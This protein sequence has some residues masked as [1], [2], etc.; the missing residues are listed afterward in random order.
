MKVVVVCE[1]KTEQ[2]LR[3]ALCELIQQQNPLGPRVGV[4]PVAVYGRGA[5]PGIKVIVE[6]QLE[7]PDVSGVILLTDVY[8][9]FRDARE[10]K[11]KL[12]EALGDY[13]RHPKIRIHVAQFEVEAWVIPFWEDICKSLRKRSLKAPPQKP[14]DKP[15][16]I[17]GQK[18]PSRHLKDL[19][20][21]AK[22]RYEKVKDGPKW[23]T[24]R[25][26]GE[27]AKV[28]PELRLFL[29]SLLEFAS[30]ERLP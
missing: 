9:D 3:R 25:N 22:T 19:Y 24:A 13:G 10:A 21:K 4:K 20:R 12:R 28:C 17:N 1:G 15:E 30:A 5:Y 26:L 16:E 14:G 11:D 7:A 27:S 2:A 8:P 6:H 23:L 18:P 29:D